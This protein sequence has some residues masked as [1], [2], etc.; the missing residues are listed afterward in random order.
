[1]SEVGRR[2]SG[3]N[4]DLG[5]TARQAARSACALVR[6][7][8]PGLADCDD[9]T[10]ASSEAG[11][12]MQHA[13][14]ITRSVNHF[15]I[16]HDLAVI[17][18]LDVHLTR[19]DPRDPDENP[20]IHFLTTLSPDTASQPDTDDEII[21]STYHQFFTPA[22]RRTYPTTLIAN[23]HTFTDLMA[24]YA[25]NPYAQYLY[26]IHTYHEEASR[27]VAAEWNLPLRGDSNLL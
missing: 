2:L 5:K 9:R 20:V 11:W 7:E 18:T 14:A 13:K 21:D 1:M 12:C 17:A 10:I 23:R 27:I 15:F 8:N 22:L 3:F 16:E 4:V 19:P 26:D 6:S 24:N 25:P